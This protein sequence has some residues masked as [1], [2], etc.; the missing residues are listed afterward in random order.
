M[1]AAQFRID[2]GTSGVPGQARHDLV[3]GQ[4]ITLVATDGGS[5]HTW[6]ILDKVGSTATLNT[7]TGTTVIVGPG[8]SITQPCAFLVRLTSVIGGVTYITERP[9][10]VVTLN[11]GL[12]IPLFPEKAPRASTLNSHVADDSSD[13][14]IYPDLSGLGVTT[15]NWRGW[16]EW[17][18]QFVTIVDTIVAGGGGPPT[19]AAGGDLSGTYPNPGVAKIRGRTVSAS[20]PVEGQGFVWNGS[21]YSFSDSG[22]FVGALDVAVTLGS[23]VYPNGVFSTFGKFF[24]IDGGDAAVTSSPLAIVVA[25][26]NGGPIVANSLAY[27]LRQGLLTGINVQGSPAI[28]LTVYVNDAGLFSTNPGSNSRAVGTILAGSGVS[29]S[30][31]FDGEFEAATAGGGG[32]ISPKQSV[33]VDKAGNDGTGTRGDAS[34]PFLTVTAAAAALVNGDILF[35]GPGVFAEAGTIPIP[36]GVTRFTL[37]GSGRPA[38]IDALTGGATIGTT[39]SCSS[40]D[41]FSFPN[42]QAAVLMSDVYLKTTTSGIAVKAT[43]V[44]GIAGGTMLGGLVLNRILINAE[45]GFSLKD[46]NGVEMSEV[47]VISNSANCDITTCGSLFMKQCFITGNDMVFSYDAADGDAPQ[48]G[49]QGYTVQSCAFE[50]IIL[51][52]QVLLS[53]DE[54]STCNSFTGSG[55]NGSGGLGLSLAWFGEVGGVGN[56]GGINF[57]ALPDIAAL[58]IDFS[59][60]R[61]R[62][63]SGN[64]IT[65]AQPPSPT[66]PITINMRGVI[67]EGANTTRTLTA[68]YGCTV[69]LRGAHIFQVTL[70]TLHSGSILTSDGSVG[71]TNAVFVDKSGND[72][73]AVRGNRARPFLT[74]RAALAATSNKDQIVIGPGLFDE[75]AGGAFMVPPGA[76]TEL[77]IIGSGRAPRDASTLF[78]TTAGTTIWHSG[79]S[80]FSFPNTQVQVIIKDL[81]IKSAA[82]GIIADGSG[83]GGTVMQMGILLE[84]CT[85]Q[86]NSA[87]LNFSYL[88]VVELHDCELVTGNTSHFVTCSHV[89]LVDVY[90]NGSLDLE[91]DQSSSAKPL[92]GRFPYDLSG[93]QVEGAIQLAA[94]PS[95]VA[96]ASCITDQITAS[97]LSTSGGLT[98]DFH[99]HGQ[100]GTPGAG[101]NSGKIFDNA[102]NLVDVAGNVIDFR[103]AR[104]LGV[105]D[106]YIQQSAGTHTNIVEMQG[107]IISSDADAGKFIN[108]GAGINL[109]LT[110]AVF[111]LGVQ[112]ATGGLA[113]RDRAI[114]PAQITTDV[115]NYN[116][117]NIKSAQ[118]LVLDLDAS[119]HTISGIVT[120]VGDGHELIVFNSTGFSVRLSNADTNSSAGNRFSFGQDIY[121]RPKQFIFLKYYWPTSPS[122]SGLWTTDM[123]YKVRTPVTFNANGVLTG[124]TLGTVSTLTNAA[125][126]D[127]TREVDNYEIITNMILHVATDGSSG[128]T[129]A[130]VYRIRSGTPTLLGSISLASGGGNYGRATLVP[131]TFAKQELLADD[132]L[133]VQLT[134]AAATAA[135]ASIEVQFG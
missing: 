121:L 16:A 117:T 110:G 53:G 111:G 25:T 45:T 107:C 131:S 9:F 101:G 68:D 115:N 85:I 39:I 29:W 91:W 88:T 81:T 92:T 11:L 58:T 94:Q 83:G 24:E 108:A 135:N 71:W 44:G 90:T 97:G 42:T 98:I 130:E 109:D 89:R 1:T 34:K 126:I 132:R 31:W 116:P 52:K 102:T 28:G 114:F 49:R 26:L 22:K 100:V 38:L 47:G 124:A 75:T 123:R 105:T 4:A 8:G 48:I 113:W 12:R 19:G 46:L 7:T 66:F 33:Y 106:I 61:L 80:V 60:A 119:G 79:D 95:V 21:Q 30:V 18:Y 43:G 57:S 77:T 120:P 41:L 122:F 69:D 6:E 87:P 54:A 118:R 78:T 65:F 67:V 112:V 15:Q 17:V 74:V 129:T 59:G 76:V 84:N 64:N 62:G 70:T 133:V 40:A 20:A 127:G 73:T 134:A 125:V 104:L 103:G 99:W 86:G 2:Q 128:T 72:S 5:S 32:P 56:G 96:S 27:L 13:N 3:P 35:V 63:P 10:S 55:L 37:F 23:F 93:V 14:A 36:V 51:A 50:D 82:T